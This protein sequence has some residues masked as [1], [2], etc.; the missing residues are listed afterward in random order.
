MK[1]IGIINKI[2]AFSNVDGP[3]NRTAVFFQGCNLKCLYCHNPETIRFCVGCG[4]CIEAC[5]AGALDQC[6]P[7]PFS[8]HPEPI[9]PHPEPLSCH[10]ERSE[11]S[12]PPCASRDAGEG[13]LPQPITWHPSRCIS[14]DACIKAC[15]H[16][17]SPKLRY[18]TPEDLLSEIKKTAPY[19]N[20][21][22]FS[23][24]ECTLQRD[25]L[26]EVIPL[27]RQLG[28]GVLLDSNGTYDFEKDP[29]LLEMIDGVML[30]IKA[31]DPDFCRA[32]TGAGPELPIKNLKYLQSVGKLAE[33][34]TVL[35]PE[36]SGSS[37][38]K[39]EAVLVTSSCK[40]TD[41]GGFAADDGGKWPE[42]TGEGES[43]P[44]PGRGR[45]WHGEAV[46]GEGDLYPT[47][48][49]NEL[50]VRSVASLLAPSIPYKLLR[51]RPFGVRQEG[52]DI[53][54]N[55]ITEESAAQALAALARSLGAENCRVV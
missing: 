2:I 13:D 21:V 37:G 1:K 24:G 17:A 33:V 5:P 47:H 42:G 50:T 52:I 28:L 14:C 6:H 32:L 35:L 8:C 12:H 27:I 11:G 7:E 53:I 15:P 19:I 40:P 43:L 51:Y 10:P 9:L 22:S 41:E 46:T 48:S 49:M 18:M 25:F 39:S 20:G 30:D 44:S 16:L 23:G 54:G 31:V 36:G 34:R 45:G 3:G 4:K 55:T 38:G 26:V 29:E